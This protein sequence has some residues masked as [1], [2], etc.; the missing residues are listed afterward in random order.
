VPSIAIKHRLT[1]DSPPSTI[2]LDSPING[3][4]K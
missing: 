1:N 4:W 2:D 3:D